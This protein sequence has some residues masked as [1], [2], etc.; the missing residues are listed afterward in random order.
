VMKSDLESHVAKLQLTNASRLLDLGCGSGGVLAFVVGLTGC[1]GSGIDLSAPAITA[2]RTRAASLG[3]GEKLSFR[4]ADLNQTLPY[5]NGSFNAVLCLDAILHLSDRFAIFREIKRLLIPGG[6]FLF[7]DAAVIT[8]TVSADEFR[9]RANRGFTQFVPPG[10]NERVLK[11]SGFEIIDVI[12]RTPSLLQTA[13]SRLKARLAHARELKDMEGAT[14]FEREQQYL[15][16]V[17]ELS[18]RR[19]LSRMIYLARTGTT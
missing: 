15:R 11:D 16:V 2:A 17:V 8:G 18:Q 5:L 4:Q 13:N 6:R 19:A 14:N 3:C 7:T 9:L 12:D 1:H 10:V